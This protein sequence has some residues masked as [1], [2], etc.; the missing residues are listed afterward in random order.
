MLIETQAR[1]RRLDMCAAALIASDSPDEVK[2]EGALYIAGFASFLKGAQLKGAS[3]D[4]PDVVEF[5]VAIDEF[6][7][8]VEANTQGGQNHGNQ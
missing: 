2:G 7:D 4:E 6:C 3:T 8:M 1:L 5:V